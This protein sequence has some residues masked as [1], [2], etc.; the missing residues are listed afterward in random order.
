MALARSAVV[1]DVHVLDMSDG[2]VRVPSVPFAVSING[3]QFSRDATRFA[4]FAPPTISHI[5]PSSGSSA[6]ARRRTA[7]ASTTSPRTPLHLP[8][9]QRQRRRLPASRGHPHL[10]L[11]LLWT[12]S[13]G[14]SETTWWRGSTLAT[15]GRVLRAASPTHANTSAPPHRRHAD[16]GASLPL[17]NHSTNHSI[18]TRPTSRASAASGVEAAPGER[19]GLR[20]ERGRLRCERG[21]LR[22]NE[23]GSV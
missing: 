23:A 17:D 16:L 5:L 13:S 12:G 6:E 2:A 22:V 19:G 7:I 11:T 9:L 20:C 18:T 15:D 3:R 14:S 10:T 8:L 21:G 4:Y 1:D